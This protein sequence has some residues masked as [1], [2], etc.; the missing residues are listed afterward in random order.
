MGEEP[1]GFDAGRMKPLK[2]RAPEGRA[3]PS[4]I[5]VLYLASSELTCI[6]EVRPWIGAEIS[7]AQLN[8]L[9]DLRGVDLSLEHGQTSWG[10][11]GLTLKELAGEVLPDA[12]KKERIVWTDIGR[13]FS[14]PVTLSDHMADYVPTQ[15]L[16]ELFK[17]EGYDAI[18]YRS[19]FGESGY[20][21][22]LFDLADADVINCAPYMVTGLEVKFEKFASRW[23]TRKVIE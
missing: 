5:P 21:I 10:A 9:R 12:D 18:I 11:G 4:G 6:S 16:A 13:A 22:A 14:Q 23:F 8:I 15:V 1:R 17:S 2:N 7:V 3:N 20:N 19:Q